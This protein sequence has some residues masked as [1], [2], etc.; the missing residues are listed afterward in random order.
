MEAKRFKAV[1]MANATSRSPKLDSACSSQYS[2]TVRSM[3][4]LEDLAPGAVNC[5]SFNLHKF[6]P[7]TEPQAHDSI[8][9][10]VAVVHFFFWV[11]RNFLFVAGIQF[12]Q[13]LLGYSKNV[14][15]PCFS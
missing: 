4:L 9:E 1:M 14:C 12:I 15:S 11:A 8:D 10:C 3:G 2:T 6:N 13:P 5:L 7:E